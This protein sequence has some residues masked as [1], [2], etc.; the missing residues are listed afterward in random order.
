ML[1]HTPLFSSFTKSLTTLIHQM[2]N[3]IRSISMSGY[4]HMLGENGLK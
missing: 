2:H 4:V 3:I 1:L